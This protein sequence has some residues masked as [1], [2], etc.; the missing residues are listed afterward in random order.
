MPNLVDTHCHVDHYEDP[1]AV[2]ERARSADIGVVAVTES[3]S[4]YRSLRMKLG[5]KLS[6][7]EVA[8]GA[9]PLQIRSLSDFQKA[10]FFRLLP[11]V[12]FVGEVGLDFSSQGMSSRKTQIAFFE[13]LL[14]DPNAS[15][16]PMTVH[17]RA[18]ATSAIPMLE[19]AG[20]KP[21]L[22]W[23][24]GPS[25][26]IDRALAGGM[27]FSV[28]PSMLRS[29]SGLRVINAVPRDRALIETDGPF[30][31]VGGRPCEPTDAL[32]VLKALATAWDAS[33]EE[34]RDQLGKNLVELRS[35]SQASRRLF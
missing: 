8:L 21:V 6:N 25:N 24:T 33:V 11:D 27:Y 12:S 7:V 9:H 20:A 19:S 1:V 30:V 16:V 14:S 29:K 4:A 32:I 18:A 26:L 35:S 17:T 15:Y 22:H 13:R 23:Y 2:I 28:N 31:S 34:A 3:P 5:E 10:L